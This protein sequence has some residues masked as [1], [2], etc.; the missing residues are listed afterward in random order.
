MEISTVGMVRFETFLAENDVFISDLMIYLKEGNRLQKPRHCDEK[1]YQTMMQCWAPDKRDRPRFT[2][3]VK[4][5]DEHHR[6][7]TRNRSRIWV[8]LFGSSLKWT[9]LRRSGRSMRVELDGPND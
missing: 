7:V 9:V 1:L 8:S 4:F 6:N 2:D 5:F 3:L